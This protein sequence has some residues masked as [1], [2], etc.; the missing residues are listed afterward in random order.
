M[1]AKEKIPEKNP[2]KAGTAHQP[3][4]LAGRDAETR[5]LTEAL[6]L[7]CGERKKRWGALVSDPFPPIKIVGP[8]G[9]GKTALLGWAEEQAKKRG[10]RCV[11]CEEL[12]Q[13]KEG[14]TMHEL[15]ADVSI[16]PRLLRRIKGGNVN[17]VDKVGAGVEMDQ[18]RPAFASVAG[19]AVR[20]KPLLLLLDEVQ[21]FELPL[22]RAV[23]QGSQRLLRQ[24]YPLGVVLAGTPGLDRHLSKAEAT[25]IHRS[26]EIYINRLSDEATR[27]ALQ[28][29]FEQ[30]KI[31]VTTEALEAMAA[32][33][34]NY[35]FFIQVV[36]RAVWD[37]MTEAGRQ[38][39]DITLVAKIEERARTRRDSFYE[40][41]RAELD[42]HNVMPYVFQ[43]I[44]LLER[45]QGRVDAL[46]IVAA[47]VDAN[48]DIDRERAHEIS[49]ILRDQGLFWTVDGN[50]EPGIPS[51]F[52]YCKARRQQKAS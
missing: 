14:H 15:L 50:A 22:L 49:S 9:V 43:I 28:K 8:R 13:N 16:I 11:S 29:P 3:P 44:E 40:K 12:T 21:H 38:D 47:L 19:F 25:F 17:V 26:E 51:F 39:V 35:P 2:F 20:C 4:L 36:G 7:L 27:A 5:L 31:A 23:L 41:G 37:A 24:R 34:D 48:P 42:E 52:S 30:E 18:F 6:D 33:T 32:Q 45:N 1:A 10:I 46:A